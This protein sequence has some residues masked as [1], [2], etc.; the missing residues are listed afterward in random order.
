MLAF[1]CAFSTIFS[2][3]CDNKQLDKLSLQDIKAEVN[4]GAP[5][6]SLPM[7]TSVYRQA[8]LQSKSGL[9]SAGIST[10]PRSCYYIKNRP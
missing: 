4:L 7:D 5:P 10:V 8:I 2:S 9:G 6:K 3:T 1:S